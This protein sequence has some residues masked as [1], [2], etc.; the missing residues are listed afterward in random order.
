MAP[1]G[2]TDRKDKKTVNSNDVQLDSMNVEHAVNENNLKK[3]F[4]KHD[5][6]CS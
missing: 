1:D 5:Y 6:N 3:L 2:H 4:K